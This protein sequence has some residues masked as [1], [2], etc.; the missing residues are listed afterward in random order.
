LYRPIGGYLNDFFAQTRRF[1]RA[2]D[3][4]ITS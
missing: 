1:S 3:R 4:L 2:A